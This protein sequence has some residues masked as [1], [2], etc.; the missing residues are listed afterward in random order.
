[1]APQLDEVKKWENYKWKIKYLDL[2]KDDKFHLQNRIFQIILKSRGLLWN[3][4][5]CG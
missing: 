1:L 4:E 5:I 2:V 3:L